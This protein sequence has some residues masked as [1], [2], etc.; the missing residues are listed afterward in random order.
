MIMQLRK[1]ELYTR[2]TELTFKRYVIS[3]A[4]RPPLT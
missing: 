2:V 3:S 4:T 1:K